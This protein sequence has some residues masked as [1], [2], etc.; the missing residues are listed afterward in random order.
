[1]RCC[2][3]AFSQRDQR[4][5]NPVLIRVK[6]KY[7]RY[8]NRNEDP[9]GQPREN[10]PHRANAPI[11]RHN[12]LRVAERRTTLFSAS[13]TPERTPCDGGAAAACL[14]RQAVPKI[15]RSSCGFAASLLRTRR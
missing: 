7:R 3:E 6:Q 15:A 1:M 10:S 4:L 9:G 14:Q 13:F 11:D 8:D 2:S 12:S 5:A